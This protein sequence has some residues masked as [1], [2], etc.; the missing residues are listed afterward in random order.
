MTI[1]ASHRRAAGP[2]NGRKLPILVAAAAL[3][4]GQCFPGP[5]RAEN[6]MGYQLLT[7][8]AAAGLPRNHGSLG[9]DAERSQQIT[10][11]GMTFDIIRVK[12]VRRG[13]PAAQA[14]FAPGDQIIAVDGQVFANLVAFAAYVGSV[15]PGRTVSVD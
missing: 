14:G 1:A 2:G 15:Q 10:D 5:V 12:E 8:Q 11:G 6:Q 7:P 9:L 13:S 4:V 3:L